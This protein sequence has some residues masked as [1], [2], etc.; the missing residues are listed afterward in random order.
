MI[1]RSTVKE[2]VDLEFSSSAVLSLGI[3]TSVVTTLQ[4][5]LNHHAVITQWVQKKLS[6]CQYTLDKIFSS[7]VNL[8]GI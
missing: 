5:S 4:I 7:L 3:P 1:T 8:E 2:T 6:L